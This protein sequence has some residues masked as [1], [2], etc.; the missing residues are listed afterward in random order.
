MARFAQAWDLRQK[1]RK[2]RKSDG[3]W[4]GSTTGRSWQAVLA[5]AVDQYVEHTL[6]DRFRQRGQRFTS[7][8]ATPQIGSNSL[9]AGSSKKR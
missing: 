2:L 6:P 9:R 7:D 5:A 1:T 3:A 8:S 4:S